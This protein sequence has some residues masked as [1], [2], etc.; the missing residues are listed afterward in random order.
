MVW[1]SQS[2]PKVEKGQEMMRAFFLA[3]Q[4]GQN[5]LQ[6]GLPKT[7]ST[8]VTFLDL[9]IMLKG[10]HLN[11]CSS[12][13]IYRCDSHP[14]W[15]KIKWTYREPT[16]NILIIP[17][18]HAFFRIQLLDSILMFSMMYYYY[19]LPV[20]FINTD[21]ETIIISIGMTRKILN[22]LMFLTWPMSYYCEFK[23]W[24]PPT[25]GLKD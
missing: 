16:N 13:A 12:G 14:H 2:P 22:L 25:K 17:Y 6:L 24:L 18:G 20:I 21:Q 4:G 9:T 19:I 11:F 1:F 5:C 15:N 7:V 3:G 23:E 10:L 8:E